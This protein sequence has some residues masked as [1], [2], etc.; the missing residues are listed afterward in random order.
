MIAKFI[1]NDKWTSE[2]GCTFKPNIFDLLIFMEKSAKTIWKSK[3]TAD[4]SKQRAE[5]QKIYSIW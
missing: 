5:S 4:K 3:Q 2:T 1:Y